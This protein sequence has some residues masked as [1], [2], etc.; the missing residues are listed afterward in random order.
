M[1]WYDR[2]LD[3]VLATHPDA[4]HIGGIPDV[5]KQF[6]VAQYIEPGI[7]G[8]STAYDATLRGL[9]KELA[10]RIIARRGQ[11]INFGDGVFLRILFPD[12][13]MNGSETNTASVIAQLIYGETE[14]LLTGDAPMKIEQYVTE[15][16]GERLKSD[17]LKAGHHGSKTSTGSAFVAAVSP[18]YTV[19]SAGKDNR[20]GHPHKDVLKTLQ[21]AS[22]TILGTYEQGRIVFT[23]DGKEVKQKT[24]FIKR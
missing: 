1:P 14:F 12:R 2:S 20:Y 3:V 23:S 19:I 7:E 9:E 16:E 6:K 11:V 21:E 10:G 18:T 8:D 13:D 24:R 5:L 4:D 22:T 15:L 17:V